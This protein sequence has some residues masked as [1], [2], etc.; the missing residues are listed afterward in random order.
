MLDCTGSTFSFDVHL[1]GKVFTPVD[2]TSRHANSTIGLGSEQPV[3]FS[4][5]ATHALQILESI[6]SKSQNFTPLPA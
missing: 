3:S 4:W 6:S 2:F 1:A 5:A